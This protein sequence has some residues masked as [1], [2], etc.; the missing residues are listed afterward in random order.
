M[1]DAI[2]RGLLAALPFLDSEFLH[3]KKQD[4]IPLLNGVTGRELLQKFGHEFGRAL[5]SEIWIKSLHCHL[6]LMKVDLR[7]VVIDDVR[8]DNEIEYIKKQN[9][10]IIGVDRPGMQEEEWMNHSSEN[11]LSQSLVDEW[12]ANISCYET[13]LECAVRSVMDRILD[14]EL[15]PVG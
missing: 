8:Y 3:D 10:T 6:D 5:D 11:S 14:P 7:K 9:G 15:E 4:G 13:D 2:R 12:V 1:A